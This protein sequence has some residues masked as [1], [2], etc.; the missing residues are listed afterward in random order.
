MPMVPLWVV[1][2][3][4]GAVLLAMFIFLSA[5]LSNRADR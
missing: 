2:T 5:R 1:A 4:C 3:A